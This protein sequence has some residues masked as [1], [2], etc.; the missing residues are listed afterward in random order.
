MCQ[1]AKK[2]LS[3]IS[4]M[5]QQYSSS[6]VIPNNGE[7]RYDEDTGSMYHVETRDAAKPD[8]ICYSIVM[9]AFANSRLP[10]AGIVSYRLLGA[11]ESKY[12]AGDF[13][14]KPSTRI[15][16]AVIQSLIHSEFIGLFDDSEEIQKHQWVN[17]AEVAMHI[18]KR[19]K[20]NNVSPN[21]FTYNYIINC[22]A[23]CKCHELAEAR[24][25]FEVALRAFQELRNLSNDQSS[26]APNDTNPDSFTYAFMLKACNNHLP[27]GS[28]VRAKTLKHTFKE[29]CRTGHL[30]SAV[31]DRLYNGVSNERE[32][33]EITGMSQ[34][35]LSNQ[36]QDFSLDLYDLPTSWSRRAIKT[37]SS[38]EKAR[39]RSTSLELYQ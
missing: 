27:K 8:L 11:L 28:S 26:T 36:R 20:A 4:E 37:H 30:N 15:Y 25:S 29:C 32:F 9:D 24:I 23:E 21:S 22:A 31:L 1:G 34:V 17:N 16:T 12:Q 5:E 2:A 33:Y 19:M 35:L 39:R 18:L 38:K 14:M 6:N 10:E 13:S 7:E 3:L